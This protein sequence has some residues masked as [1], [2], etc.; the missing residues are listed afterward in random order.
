MKRLPSGLIL[1]DTL[2]LIC[3]S[4]SIGSSLSYLIRKYKDRGKIDPIILELR[5]KSPVLPICIDGTP[6][7]IPS[8]RGGSEIKGFSLLIKNKKLLNLIFAVIQ[9]NKKRKL[10]RLLQIH[11]AL[12][13]A[14]LTSSVGI[15]FGAGGY[16]DYTQIMLII[17]PSTISGFL[18]SNLSS[19]YLVAMILPLLIVFN[20]GIED[21]ED[22][23]Q[24]CLDLCKFAEQFHNKELLIEMKKLDLFVKEDQPALSFPIICIEEKLSLLQRYKL[25]ELIVNEKNRNRVKHFAEFI[26][27]F[28]DCDPYI[29]AIYEEVVEKT[30]E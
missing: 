11:F 25:K 3:I 20:R 19:N 21:I 13:N 14:L 18:V 7:K 16:S 6:L 8:F 2:D 22:P 5:E 15:R 1:L 27:K 10:F 9:L 26:K 29:D 17:L 23:S 28:P 30:F 4:F 12:M 24:K